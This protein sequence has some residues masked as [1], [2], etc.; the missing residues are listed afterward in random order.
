MYI[1][2]QSRRRSRRH[3][4]KFTNIQKTFDTYTS[5][6]LI[7]RNRQSKT[8]GGGVGLSYLDEPRAANV[9]RLNATNDH[10]E[11]FSIH[12]TVVDLGCSFEGEKKNAFP[13]RSR[14]THGCFF[15][16]LPT[17]C[18]RE[19]LPLGAERCVLFFFLTINFI[20]SRLH[21]RG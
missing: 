13:I 21:Q 1:Q 11:V 6:R 12:S 16:Q 10:S 4:R 15:I 17:R 18:S 2:K 19:G 20:Q 7:T 5:R 14:V 3:S 9:S 8:G